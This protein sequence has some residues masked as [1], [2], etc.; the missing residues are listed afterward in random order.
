MPM[1]DAMIAW[2]Q[3]NKAMAGSSGSAPAT[4]APTSAS[5]AP[6]T[7][8]PA[9]STPVASVADS[10]LPP[11]PTPAPATS[12]PMTDES[13]SNC[14]K[15]LTDRKFKATKGEEIVPGDM[16]C[17]VW[18][19]DHIV[20]QEDVRAA[21]LAAFPALSGDPI[22]LAQYVA[23]RWD[24]EVHQALV[25]S[26]SMPTQASPVRSAPDGVLK[27]GIDGQTYWQPAPVA[28]MVD[29]EPVADDTW[30]QGFFD[31]YAL[32]APSQNGGSDACTFNGAASTI[33]AV[34][35]QVNE[36]AGLAGYKPNASRAKS[37]AADILKH[38]A[39]LQQTAHDISSDVRAVSDSN[40]KMNQAAQGLQTV[41]GIGT[42]I[43]GHWY[44]KNLNKAGASGDPS[45]SNVDTV[46][47]YQFSFNYVNHP[48]NS[49]GEEYAGQLTVQYNVL[50]KLWAVLAG[51]QF[52]KVV[53]IWELVKDRV[54]VQLQ[55]VVGAGGGEILAQD[56][57]GIFQGQ[58]GPQGVLQ[59]GSAQISVMPFVGATV[60]K[61]PATIDGGVQIQVALTNDQRNAP[62]MAQPDLS[63]LD[64]PKLTMTDLLGVLDAMDR[65]QLV[66]LG[67]YRT[68]ERV[69][70]ARATVL[71]AF[72]DAT[73]KVP[74][75]GIPDTSMPP[76]VKRFYDDVDSLPSAD[77]DAVH[78]YIYAHI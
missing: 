36:Q 3:R 1:N 59:I 54:N 13:R 16:Q 11:S 10:T 50:T 32:A 74:D 66:H 40:D 2:L 55:I 7:S 35:D 63:K 22:G 73:G 77:Q 18:L 48:N 70:I 76:E 51:G 26:G 19:D 78:K 44:M 52:T 42:Q 61:D 72:R 47:Q 14:D 29:A 41:A 53:Q 31:F 20:E 27:R 75:S 57:E 46:G 21:L 30:L 8:A 9:V 23:D 12:V 4:S 45:R 24:L 5:S 58:I 60:T 64:D 56:A 25:F 39:Q 68:G 6:A 15:Y 67:A 62:A 49:T 17:D 37:M 34:V 65:A 43:S 38:S 71:G 33:S 28:T 69:R